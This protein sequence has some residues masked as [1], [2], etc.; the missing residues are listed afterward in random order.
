[1][2]K[3]MLVTLTLMV[4]VAGC[5]AGDRE[6]SAIAPEQA[7]EPSSAELAAAPLPPRLAPGLIF[8]RRPGLYSA[9]QFAARSDW[10]STMGYDRAP[11]VVLYRELFRDRQGPGRSF[12]NSTY[13]RFDM[14]RYGQA[15]R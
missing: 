4:A 7:V 15:V 5:A 8:N 14:A 13:R 2:S 10:P 3:I 12:N 11:E 1:M 6:P 9:D